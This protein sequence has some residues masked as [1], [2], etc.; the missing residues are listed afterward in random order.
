[1]TKKF[2]GIPEKLESMFS[3]HPILTIM[4]ALVYLNSGGV[5]ISDAMQMLTGTQIVKKQDFDTLQSDV[6]S[7]T[8]SIHDL[9]NIVQDLKKA[10][11]ESNK[12]DDANAKTLELILKVLKPKSQP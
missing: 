7:N 2:K 8:E 3:S 1:M 10:V 12:N 4:V 11:D 6:S 5:N 9:T